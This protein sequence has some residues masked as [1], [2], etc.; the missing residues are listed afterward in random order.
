M[1]KTRFA[2]ASAERFVG[3]FGDMPRPFT[4]GVYF[5]SLAPLTAPDHI[6][7]ALIETLDFP[8][9]TGER[10]RRTPR[11]QILDYLR[12]KRL[13]LIMDNFE[14][15]LDGVEL[16]TDILKTAPEVQIVATSRERLHLQQEQI[17]AIQGLEF[18]DWETPEDAT[19]YT[20]SKLFIQ[21]ARR[22]QH[23]FRLQTEDLTYLTRITRLVEGMPLAIELAAAWVDMLS[24][25]GIAAEIQKSLDFLETDVRDIPERHRSIRAVFDT[26]W[27]QMSLIE[28]HI[29]P[30]LSVFRGG[31]THKAAQALIAILEGS[32]PALRL[33]GRLASKS[34]L[35][36]NQTRDR[37]Q[38]HELLRQ[39]GAELLATNV[40]DEADMRDRHSDFYCAALAVRLSDLKGPRQEEALAEIE[41]DFENVRAAWHWAIQKK[42]ATQLRQAADCLGTYLEWQG[43]YQTGKELFR[44]AVEALQ[45]AKDSESLSLLVRVRTWKSVFYLALG[46]TEEAQLFLQQ[47]LDLLQDSRLAALDTR[48]DRSFTLQQLGQCAAR[49]DAATAIDHFERSLTLYQEL[50]ER[51]AVAR[52][53]TAL[54]RAVR[55]IADYQRARG[56]GRESLDLLR[57]LGDRRGMVLTLQHL[58]QLARYESR[59]QEAL[60]LAQEAVDL[61]RK[62]GNRAVLAASLKELGFST[63]RVSE[64]ERARTILEESLK[65]LDEFGDSTSFHLMDVLFKLGMVSADLGEYDHARHF[66]NRSLVVAR[67]SGN[68]A[69]VGYPLALLGVI[70]LVEGAF[71]QAREVLKDAIVAHETARELAIQ[72]WT[73]AYLALTERELGNRSLVHRLLFDALTSA[74]QIGDVMSLE[75]ILPIIALVLSQQGHDEHAAGLWML[76]KMRRPWVAKE[77]VARALYADKLDE[78]VAA[79]PTNKE[80]A[81]RRRARQHDMWQAAADLLVELPK[82]GW[83]TGRMV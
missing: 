19:D 77:A 1:G 27:Q 45:A 72:N 18:P 43:R 62:I 76:V 48:F 29:F 44:V 30:Q 67:N 14:H 61:A 7:Q 50:D 25:A 75:T 16:V 56:L 3:T 68:E 71:K 78:L 60:L 73:L 83:E 10:Q 69:S 35:Q 11:Q 22:I 32:P 40:Q 20:A 49:T 51:W 34:L 46:E 15:L 12:Q 66:A 2:L 38:I 55:S 5:V 28:C 23:D 24:L 59:L 81:A 8:L 70:L 33:L 31:F 53:L 82:L 79:L 6:V 52:V 36:Y 74:V 13:L 80:A 42:R 17:F 41:A 9:E 21:S 54:T 65:I 26:S 63:Y 57:I 4:D 39:Y 58:S 37:Y 47:N 64:F